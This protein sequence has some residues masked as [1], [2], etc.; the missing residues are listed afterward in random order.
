[1]PR[2]DN[3]YA[4]VASQPG[5]EDASKCDRPTDDRL[6]VAVTTTIDG[7]PAT[8]AADQV[9][10]VTIINAYQ[11][12]GRRNTS[13]SLV[14]YGH[15]PF[16]ARAP[17]LDLTVILRLVPVATA[18]A[19]LS[20]SRRLAGQRELRTFIGT[21]TVPQAVRHLARPRTGSPAVQRSGVTSSQAPTSESA[22]NPDVN[23]IGDSMVRQL[24]SRAHFEHSTISE[25][26]QMSRSAAR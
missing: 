24:K 26:S 22:R 9:A 4:S 3:N 25:C 20:A 7:S 10:E 1:M 16:V 13:P 19:Q 5:A 11:G 15:G 18:G 23:C 12:I 21:S 17:R 8:I 6:R 14:H 2:L